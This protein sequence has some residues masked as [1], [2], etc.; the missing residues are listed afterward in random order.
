M[1]DNLKSTRSSICSM[2]GTTRSLKQSLASGHFDIM[3]ASRGT[4]VEVLDFCTVKWA[5]SDE[6][7]SLDD[8]PRL[9]HSKSEERRCKRNS[10]QII[11]V[12]MKIR[13]PRAR[14]IARDGDLPGGRW[15][16][17]LVFSSII[18]EPLYTRSGCDQSTERGLAGRNT[19][20][21]K[22]SLDSASGLS[23]G[24]LPPEAGK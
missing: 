3:W 16:N 9:N 22:P 15:P 5:K 1:N 19:R 21:T 10:V 8:W 13:T 18:E 4:F 6:P 14:T 12:R 23:Q 20:L 17:R 2:A 7:C 11:T 24:K